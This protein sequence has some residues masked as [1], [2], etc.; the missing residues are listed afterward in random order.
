M[1]IV[2]LRSDIVTYYGITEDDINYSTE[3]IGF[4][5]KKYL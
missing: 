3:Q 4:V 2:D 5:L 1:K